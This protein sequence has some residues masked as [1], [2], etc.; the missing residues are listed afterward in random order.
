VP[1]ELS[2][3]HRDGEI[4][5]VHPGSSSLKLAVV[6]P[7]GKVL[8]TETLD[9]VDGQVEERAITGVLERLPA[10][11]A[12]GVR[13]VHGGTN[14]TA[15]TLV[16][17]KVIEALA[18]LSDLAPLHNPPAVAALRA[19]VATRPDLP[20]VVCFDT[21]FHATLSPAASTYAVPIHWRTG[22]ESSPSAS[23]SSSGSSP[24]LPHSGAWRCCSP[25]RCPERR[26]S[27]R[28]PRCLPW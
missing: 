6:A 3:S 14:F 15:P 10:V 27:R 13:V 8:P 4:L 2:Q 28:S 22:W 18:G 19:L 21:A 9:H 11:S 23:P 24:R 1:T 16:D 17:E 5:V 12:A 7:D 25:T 20:L 26:V